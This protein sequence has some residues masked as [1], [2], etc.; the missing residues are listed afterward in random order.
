MPEKKVF[1]NGEI[2]EASKAFLPFDDRCFRFGHGL[3]ETL[4]A[5]NGK[6]F[7]LEKHLERM[8]K[9]SQTLGIDFP[10]GV[11]EIEEAIAKLIGANGLGDSDARIRITITGGRGASL[12]IRAE[13][14][15][16]VL[17]E[18]RHYTPPPKEA[19][20]E[21]VSLW[22]SSIRRNLSSPL[23]SIKSCNYMD[24]LLAHSEA[25]E[26]DSFD[27]VMLATDGAVAEAA[28]SNIFMAYKNTL[29]TPQ[30]GGI[31]PGITRLAVIELSREIGLPLR[32]IVISPEDLLDA[33]E[34]FLTNSMIEILPVR[35]VGGKRLREC[36]GSLTSRL[37]DAYKKLVR[38]ETESGATL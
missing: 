27:A 16:S 12:Q 26:R 23:S 30:L 2:V 17:I 33:D 14:K 37:M 4:R 11:E 1:L 35:D 34:V 3:F 22:I 18:A 7:L 19:Y 13:G 32:E 6:P 15:P 29:L 38:R 10:L 25:L 8:K 36:P 24:C 28:T 20:L 31:L 5:Y 9:S 21:G